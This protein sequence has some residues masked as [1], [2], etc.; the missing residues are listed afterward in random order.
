MFDRNVLKNF[1]LKFWLMNEQICFLLSLNGYL[2]M[3]LKS[4]HIN[5]NTAQKLKKKKL[6]KKEE[7]NLKS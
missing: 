6:G 1:N 7:E 3:G 2:G 5:M 4:A